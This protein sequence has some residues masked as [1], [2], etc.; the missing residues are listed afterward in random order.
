M[1]LENGALQP[2]TQR[3]RQSLLTGFKLKESLDQ[4]LLIR[5]PRAVAPRLP[6]VDDDQRQYLVTRLI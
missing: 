3:F 2:F 5:G 6:I 4:F 1:G